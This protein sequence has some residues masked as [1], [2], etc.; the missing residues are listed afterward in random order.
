[1]ICF[2]EYSKPSVEPCFILN[3]ITLYFNPFRPKGS[4][5][6]PKEKWLLKITHWIKVNTIFG[7]LVV[8]WLLYQGN[9]KK[10]MRLRPNWQPRTSWTIRS[11]K[12][13]IKWHISRVK[14]CFRVLFLFIR[15]HRVSF[16]YFKHFCYFLGCSRSCHVLEFRT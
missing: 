15:V 12:R 10:Y 1:M 7:K 16:I 8:N 9:T 2:A 4:C 11:S 5:M 3:T 6:T 14:C 13:K